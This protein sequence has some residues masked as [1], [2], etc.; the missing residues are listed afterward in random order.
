MKTKEKENTS[1]KGILKLINS[2]K[3]SE[4][5]LQSIDNSNINDD[6][7]MILDLFAKQISSEYI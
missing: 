5:E 6:I 2:N 4:D 1:P 7:K 3:N